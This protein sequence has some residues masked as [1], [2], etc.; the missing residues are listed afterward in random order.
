[1]EHFDD[2]LNRLG[3]AVGHADRH[4]PLRAYLTG[5]LLPGERKSVEPMAAKIDPC[6]VQ[7]RHQSMHHLVASAPWDD[8][9]LMRVARDYA[10]ANFE[11]HAPVGA[12]VVDDTGIPKKGKHSVGVARQYCGVLGKQDNCQVAVT[13]SLASHVMSMPGAYRLYLPESWAKDRRRRRTAGVPD[14]VRFQ[15][16]WQIALDEIDHLLADDVP[17][18]PV[19]AD[20]GYGNVTEFRDAL[21]ARRFSYAVGINSQ[22]AVWLPGT[23]PLPPAPRKRRGKPPKLL[24][25][26]RDHQPVTVAT[27]AR[28]LPSRAWR[29]VRWREGTRGAMRSRFA[30]VRARP[31]HRDI[32]RTEPRAPEWLLI[33]WP[34]GES[35]PTKYWLSTVPEDVTLDELVR[36]AKIRWR[37]ERDYQEMKD[38][39]GLDHYEGRGWRG[40]HHHGALCIAAYAF[41]I[42]ERARL[43]P[44]AALAFLRPAHLPSG[45]RPRGAGPAP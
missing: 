3:E 39:I 23:G 28:Q 19:V 15:T 8:G 36:L 9:E 38:E 37:I 20:A 29:T 24:R 31:S 43:S 25:R 13:V 42:A 40:F 21:T 10:L 4:E 5:L 27:L 14:K 7:A 16:K 17:R 6:R 18:A 45:F 35:E 22:T 33:E 26:T 30:A 12:W 34:A 1:M 41:L 11:R 2:Y 32:W 44:P